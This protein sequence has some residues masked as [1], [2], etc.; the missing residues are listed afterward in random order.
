MLESIRSN[1]SPLLVSIVV[2]YVH[3]NQLSIEKTSI[4]I[5]FVIVVEV[6]VGTLQ[7]LFWTQK[8]PEMKEL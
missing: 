3:Y 4:S 8:T 5:D 1:E 2:L 7:V 6:V